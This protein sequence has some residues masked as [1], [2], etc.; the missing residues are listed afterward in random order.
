MTGAWSPDGLT[1]TTIG[2]TTIAFTPAYVGLPV[3]SHVSGVLATATFDSVVFSAGTPNGAPTVTLTSPAQGSIYD[4]P[5]PIAFGA[6][7]SDSDGTVTKVDFFAGSTLIGTSTSAPY[8][9]SWTNARCR[10]RSRAC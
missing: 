8:T 6:T 2:Q 4:A 5:G 1:W 10:S 3:T 9:A 7:A